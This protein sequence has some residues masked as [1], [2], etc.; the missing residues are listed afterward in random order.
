MIFW[1][2]GAAY[3]PRPVF[4]RLRDKVSLRRPLGVAAQARLVL[5]IAMRAESAYNADVR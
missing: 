4:F 2:I 1:P 5:A 3:N